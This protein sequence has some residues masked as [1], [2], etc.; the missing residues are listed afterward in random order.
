MRNLTVIIFL[1]FFMFACDNSK[2]SSDSSDS[3][4]IIDDDQ[5]TD[6]DN[7]TIDPDE[8]KSDI[9]VEDTDLTEI[10][11][12]IEN[13]DNDVDENQEVPDNFIAEGSEG[14][15]C[16]GNGTCDEKLECQNNICVSD[17]EF[18]NGS[19][20]GYCYGNGSCDEKLICIEDICVVETI[21]ECVDVVN[22]LEMEHC[23]ACHPISF[24]F[25]SGVIGNGV[26]QGDK[27]LCHPTRNICVDLEAYNQNK[28]FKIKFTTKGGSGQPIIVDTDTGINWVP[29]QKVNYISINDLN[30]SIY[31][32]K[33]AGNN[34]KDNFRLPILSEIQALIDKTIDGEFLSEFPGIKFGNYIVENKKVS[35]SDGD[36]YFYNFTFND[37]NYE[38]GGIVLDRT[39]FF[40]TICKSCINL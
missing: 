9:E 14:G 31:N 3:S 21:P 13:I 18:E 23:G 36:K 2:L 39:G 11:S 24:M 20:G 34:V 10:D 15:Y 25:E 27:L 19:E 16:Y 17:N 26:C 12:E 38:I 4:I 1:M 6:L 7:P 32:F 29:T 5:L 37:A 40:L 33:Y 28:R 35:G 30:M 22:P 8:S